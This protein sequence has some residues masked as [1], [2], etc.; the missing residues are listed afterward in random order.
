[1][2]KVTTAAGVRARTRG[3]EMMTA[4]GVRRLSGQTPWTMGEGNDDGRWRQGE[5][6]G[7]G[8]DDGHWRQQEA[9]WDN[10][11]VNSDW[12]DDD[13]H[14]K[15]EASCFGLAELFGR[16]GHQYTAKQLYRYYLAARILVQKRAHG[17][18]APE[19]QAAAQQRYKATG[20]YG[21]GR[22]RG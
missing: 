1:M 5:N 20:R 6:Q 22:G 4:T 19:R 16:F 14:Y 8:N 2:E 15:R 7:K 13:K 17:K 18:S 10:T 9:Q 12:Y 11:M 3:R 21:F